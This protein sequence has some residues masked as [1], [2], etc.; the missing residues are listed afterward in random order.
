MHTELK[1]SGSRAIKTFL[2][3]TKIN[4]FEV[5]NV[6]LELFK[7][8]SNVPFFALYVLMAMITYREFLIK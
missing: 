8:I 6:L 5:F 4:T 3:M 7:Q 2:K 1:S